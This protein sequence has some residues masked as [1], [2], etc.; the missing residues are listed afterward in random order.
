MKLILTLGLLL[1]TIVVLRSIT[2]SKVRLWVESTGPWGPLIYIALWV[3]LPCFFFP[4]PLLVLPGGL[5]FGLWWGTVYTVGGALLNSLVMYWIGHRLFRDAA[6]SLAQKKLSRTTVARLKSTHQGKLFTLFF[7]LRLVPLVSYNLINYLAPIT[8][9]R[10]SAY[11]LSTFLGIVPGTVV[12]INAGDKMMD[13]S[14]PSF[15]W[16]LAVLLLLTA[17]SFVGLRWYLKREHH[18]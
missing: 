1:A 9:I 6:W 4:V 7:V 16:A 12:Y 15:W 13:V 14:S 2:P 18:D 17:L 5:V 10:L 11:L 3:F 8:E